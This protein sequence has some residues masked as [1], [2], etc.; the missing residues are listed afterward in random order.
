MLYQVLLHQKTTCSRVPLHKTSCLRLHSQVSSWS[1]S[2]QC[3]SCF[4]GT[5]KLLQLVSMRMVFTG[6]HQR[7]NKSK[8]TSNNF[9]GYPISSLSLCSYIASPS[10][11][12]I[13]CS[14]GRDLNITKQKTAINGNDKMLISLG[15]FETCV[16]KLCEIIEQIVQLCR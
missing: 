2:F 3:I 13:F 16:L 6:H 12:I 8:R 5:R 10:M 1:C 14:S 4:R 11:I 7:S 15:R 9:L